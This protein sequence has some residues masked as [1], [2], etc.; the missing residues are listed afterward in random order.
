MTFLCKS[1]SKRNNNTITIEY[2]IILDIRNHTD[3]CLRHLL[4][5]QYLTVAYVIYYAVNIARDL[6]R[7]KGQGGKDEEIFEL[8]PDDGQESVDVTES[9]TGFNVGTERYET[10][11]AAAPASAQDGSAEEETESS[12]ER[13]VRMKA[14]VEAEMEDSVPYLSDAFTADDMYKAMVSGGRL[15]NRPEMAW[16]PVDKH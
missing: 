6:Y 7:K 2:E 3:S 5:G 8:D 11:F 13:F 14:K 1:N 12:E 15:E 10:D 4:C 9:E 16:K